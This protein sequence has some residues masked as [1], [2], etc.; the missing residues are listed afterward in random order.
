MLIFSLDELER[1]IGDAA[2]VGGIVHVENFE[3]ARVRF[4]F[5]KGRCDVEL[6]DARKV[7]ACEMAPAWLR[8]LAIDG[9]AAANRN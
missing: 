1:V 3:G 7:I 5:A 8:I 4:E 9:A 6:A 2:K